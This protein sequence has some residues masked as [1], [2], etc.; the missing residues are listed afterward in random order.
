[1]RF[2][3]T[4]SELGEPLPSDRAASAPIRSSRGSSPGSR[5]RSGKIAGFH[6]FTFN[7]LAD[8]EQWRQRRL[9]V[10]AGVP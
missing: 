10:A 9:A 4:S 3:R 1:M 5:I 2:L 7:D 6:V 8:T